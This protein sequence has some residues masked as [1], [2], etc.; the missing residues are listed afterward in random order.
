M[1]QIMNYENII[2]GLLSSIVSSFMN[3][4]FVCVFDRPGRTMDKRLDAG[5]SGHRETLLQWLQ[6]GNETTLLSCTVIHSGRCLQVW[7]LVRDRLKIETCED[8]KIR[9]YCKVAS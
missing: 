3:T 4:R 6:P 5:V 7:Q 9:Y 2:I 8:I 1:F